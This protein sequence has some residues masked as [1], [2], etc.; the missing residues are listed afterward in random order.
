MVD[1]GPPAFRTARAKPS[2]Q[3]L[4]RERLLSGDEIGL[5]GTRTR[6]EAAAGE[7]PLFCTSNV[8]EVY[9][10]SISLAVFRFICGTGT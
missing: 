5:R 7:R 1:S 8:T 10:T 2:G 6:P 4:P 9:L 3:E